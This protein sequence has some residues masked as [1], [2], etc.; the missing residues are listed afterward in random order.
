MIRLRPA[1][2]SI[3]RTGGYPNAAYLDEVKT[4]RPDPLKQAMQACLV[5]LTSHH[6]DA[7]RDGDVQARECRGRGFIEATRDADLVKH[8]H[9]MFCS[10]D[11]LFPGGFPRSTL[12]QVAAVHIVRKG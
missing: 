6:G 2:P 12:H 3:L 1:A 10:G 5:K 4:E 11:L 7:T 8:G 9:G